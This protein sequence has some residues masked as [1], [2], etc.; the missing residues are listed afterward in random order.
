M[1]LSPILTVVES[2]VVV[3]PCTCK[4]PVTVTLPESVGLVT[5]PNST[6][7][8]AEST[9]TSISFDV[10]AKISESFRRSSESFVPSSDAEMIRLVA[11]PVSPEPSPTN[12]PVN[13]EVP[14]A[15]PKLS[16]LT[17]PVPKSG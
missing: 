1:M 3:V 15:S 14:A 11:R 7:L 5:N 2:I 9:E 4:S 16:P 13:V 8:V 6:V 12:E 10:P 17:L